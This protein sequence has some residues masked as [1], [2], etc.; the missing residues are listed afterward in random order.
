MAAT[1]EV[2]RKCKKPVVA[3]YSVWPEGPPELR[4]SPWQPTLSAEIW[5]QHF[6]TAQAQ[7]YHL[8]D[9]DISFENMFLNFVEFGTFST[10][11]VLEHYAVLTEEGSSNRNTFVSVSFTYTSIA[12]IFGRK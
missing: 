8:L 5:T 12:I 2:E 4:T 7:Y 9:F 6:P 3:C 10:L 1:G 11:K